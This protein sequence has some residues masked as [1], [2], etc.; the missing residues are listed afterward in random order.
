MSEQNVVTD[1]KPEVS[2]DEAA[3]LAAIRAA[4]ASENKELGQQQEQDAP[5]APV[6]PT[7]AMEIGGLL[8]MLVSMA[9]PVLPSLGAIYTPETT[10][11]VAGAVAAVCDKHGWLQGG[12]A[13]GYSEEILAASILLPVGFATYQGVRA[14][15]AAMKPKKETAAIATEETP[16]AETAPAGEVHTPF[17]GPAITEAVR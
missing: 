13:N 6:P 2:D 14:D 8:T 5:A 16:A 7:L 12:I 4:V 10:D 11:A 1:E 17:V 9:K 15:L 3:S